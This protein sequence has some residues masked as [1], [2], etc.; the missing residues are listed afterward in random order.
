M[1]SH[2]PGSELWSTAPEG[3]V[4]LPS[5]Q[6]HFTLCLSH[7]DC[8]YSATNNRILLWKG[9]DDFSL[10]NELDTQY[11]AIYSLAVTK[12]YIITG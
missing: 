4:R 10:Q 3:W 2:S 7:Q 11:G 12:K 5:I 8:L 9:S 1:A 6:L